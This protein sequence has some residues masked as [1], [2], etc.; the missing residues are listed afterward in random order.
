MPTDRSI[1]AIYE[2]LGERERLEGTIPG[3]ATPSSGQSCTTRSHTAWTGT[4]QTHYLSYNPRLD[5]LLV[6][7]AGCSC[8]ANMD[9]FQ[10]GGREALRKGARLSLGGGVALTNQ[11]SSQ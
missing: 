3:G 9:R 10:S 2:R 7:R 11:G 8:L 4:E 1:A 6:R 5:E